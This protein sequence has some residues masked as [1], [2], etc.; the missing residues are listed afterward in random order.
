MF[1]PGVLGVYEK[2]RLHGSHFIVDISLLENDNG[3][4]NLN[5]DPR[6]LRIAP[7]VYVGEVKEAGVDCTV[8]PGQRVCVERWSYSQQDL[9]DK[10]IIADERDLLILDEETPAPGV[11]V[12]KLLDQEKKTDLILPQNKRPA[13]R[14]YYCGVVQCSSVSLVQRGEI[15]YIPVRDEF[16][17]KLGTDRLVFRVVDENSILLA[18]TPEYSLQEVNGE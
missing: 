1:K 11:V 15:I 3:I 2:F 9:D 18:L 14:P 6:K 10:H 4:I 16:Q 7:D 8:K 5:R 13:K 12:M 17:Y